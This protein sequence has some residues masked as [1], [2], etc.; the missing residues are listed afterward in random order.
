MALPSGVTRNGFNLE[1]A[2]CQLDF[3]SRNLIADSWG[4][5]KGANGPV[6]K[7]Q[8]ATSGAS[9]SLEGACFC[10]CVSVAPKPAAFPRR[11]QQ[12]LQQMLEKRASCCWLPGQLQLLP[13]PSCKG[14]STNPQ[15]RPRGSRFFAPDAKQVLLQKTQTSGHK[16]ASHACTSS[17]A[18]ASWA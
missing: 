5:G 16:T 14:S 18:P 1:A 2:W 10:L 11:F 13:G 17:S 7:L 15:S 12:R 8:N 6:G 3:L 9:R 4:S